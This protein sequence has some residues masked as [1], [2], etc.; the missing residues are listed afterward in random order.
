[1]G[2]RVPAGHV[3]K[4]E[5]ARA[6]VSLECVHA[7]PSS[8]GLC[9]PVARGARTLAGCVAAETTCGRGALASPEG[10]GGGQG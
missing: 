8:V 1:M 10:A 2:A 3:S 6:D 5:C 9:V 4:S 7:G